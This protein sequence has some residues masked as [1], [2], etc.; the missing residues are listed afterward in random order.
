M[1][2]KINSCLLNQ[3][4]KAGEVVTQTDQSSL[5]KKKVDLPPSLALFKK[6]KIKP[7]NSC[8][9]KIIKFTLKKAKTWN[10]KALT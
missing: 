2:M 4:R 1:K 8:T 5:S 10:L 3:I 6:V 7:H 9:M